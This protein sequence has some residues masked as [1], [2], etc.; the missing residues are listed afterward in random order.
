MGIMDKFEIRPRCRIDRESST[1]GHEVIVCSPQLID[2]KTREVVEEV[3]PENP[4]VIKN[5]RAGYKVEQDGDASE[6]LLQ[7]LF[8]WIKR[9]R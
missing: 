3:T 5:T 1:D 4:V 6:T 8:M 2:K 9:R 7:R